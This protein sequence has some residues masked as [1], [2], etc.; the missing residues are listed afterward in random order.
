MPNSYELVVLLD[1][2]APT[3]TRTKIITD[4]EALLKQHGEVK[5]TKAW[6]V[7]QLPYLIDHHEQAD[8]SLFRFETEPTSIA[9][10]RPRASS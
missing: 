2:D 4:A 6:G 5:A 9:H 1:A 7:R 3:D 8:Y 10:A